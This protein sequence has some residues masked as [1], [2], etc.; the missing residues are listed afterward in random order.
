MNGYALIAD[1]HPADAGI[2][3]QAFQ[4]GG[5]SYI[6]VRDGEDALATLEE[7]G[8]PQILVTDIPLGG[9][10][11]IA[12]IAYLRGIPDGKATRVL[13]ISADRAARDRAA[14]LRALLDIG[15]VLS[16]AASPDSI[17]RVLERLVPL[18]RPS[19]TFGR[20]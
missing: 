18:G 15:A 1:A 5:L 10:D 11:G 13:V 14:E 9:V 19:G 17:H 3:T 4:D 20:R 12:L 7:R 2:V 8:A 16:R 6:V